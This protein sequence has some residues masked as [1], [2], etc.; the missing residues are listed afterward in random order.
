MVPMETTERS[1][2]IHTIPDVKVW[3][4]VDGEQGGVSHSSAQ[5]PELDVTKMRVETEPSGWVCGFCTDTVAKTI[6]PV[7]PGVASIDRPQ[8]SGTGAKAK[9]PGQ[10]IAAPQPVADV[11][12]W[13]LGLGRKVEVGEV[14]PELVAAATEWA[15]AWDG[16]FEYMVDMRM[17]AKGKRG[18]SIGMAK[19]VLNCWRADLLRNGKS[20]P[21]AE[22]AALKAKAEPVTQDGMYRMDDGTIVKVQVAHHGTGNLY[23]K[24][25]VVLDE[26][27][28][29]AS[30]KEIKAEFE[31]E[32]G[33]IRKLTP[34]MKLS[35][36]EAKQYGQLYG[37]CCVCGTILTDDSPGGSIEK[38][39][40]P[41]CGAKGFWA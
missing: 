20:Q 8:S 26:V 32:P 28:V 18:L 6:A 33:L 40:G 4:T 15:K 35:L 10:A 13:L 34:A 1:T 3:L 5:C 25:M 30:G 21:K 23:A 31:Y 16:T 38:G 22:Q 2:E 19:G 37:F 39:I 41:V 29:T 27:R 36:D 12:E 9:G 11:E 24:R 14:T 17:A 7:A